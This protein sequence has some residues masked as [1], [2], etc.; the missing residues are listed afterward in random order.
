[1]GPALAGLYAKLGF[2][3]EPAWDPTAFEIE[4]RMATAQ[5]AADAQSSLDIT[6]GIRNVSNKPLP[7]PIIQLE[8]TDRWEKTLGTRMFEASE[9]LPGNSS[10]R[11]VLRPGASA[12]ITL[13]LVDPGPDAYG[14]QVDVCVPA[15]RGTVRCKADAVFD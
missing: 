13:K 11:A 10:R 12:D 5:A 9:Y 3:I 6:A 7:Y 4:A 1:V 2:P 8:L 14:F 15:G